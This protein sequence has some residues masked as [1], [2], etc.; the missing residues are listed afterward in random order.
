[1]SS[2]ATGRL[3]LLAALTGSTVTAASGSEDAS[4]TVRRPAD[5][6]ASRLLLAPTARPLPRGSGYVSDHYLFFPAAAYGVTSNVSVLAGTSLLPALG[7]ADQLKYVTPRLAVRLADGVAVA[8]G[9]LAV[10]SD[11]YAGG[12]TAGIAFAL[13]TFG[14]PDLSVT[15]G[16]GYGWIR[17][18]GEDFALADRPFLGLG[19]TWRFSPRLALVT[20]TWLFDKI[21][22]DTQPMGIA[23]RTFAD[24]WSAD[25]GFAFAADAPLTHTPIPWL[26]ITW[27]FGP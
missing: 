13:A 18:D 19:G 9:A 11:F 23:L 27:H 8:V 24:K 17:H 20:E 6:V 10:S 7:P 5:L 15:G 2:Q 21:D 3:L 16:V 1:M 22:R 26:S 25:W 4:E 12:K 14:A